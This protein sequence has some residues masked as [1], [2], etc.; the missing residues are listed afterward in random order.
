MFMDNKDF[1]NLG[2]QIR[3]SVQDAIDSMDFKQLNRTISDTVNFA[4]DEARSQMLKG[5]DAARRMDT[6]SN[7]RKGPDKGQGTGPDTNAGAY[8]TAAAA[9]AGRDAGRNA[10]RNAAGR[11]AGRDHGSWA[12]TAA[13]SGR[14]RERRRTGYES[15]RYTTER[16]STRAESPGYRAFQT[17]E[18]AGEDQ[19]AYR[20]RK[21]APSP[22]AI[23]LNQPGRISGILFTV[24]GGI[25]L[26]VVGILFLVTW[27]LA[28]VVKP[29]WGAILGS[30]GLLLVL[31]CVFGT[32]L[33]T[34]ISTR[35]R[36]KRAGLYLK[37]A[38]SRLFCDIEELA[39][40]IGK[41]RRFVVRDLQKMIEK[42]ILPEAHIDEQKTC[43]MLNEET[44]KQYLSAQQSLKQR[45]KEMA[46]LAESEKKQKKSAAAPEGKK[47]AEEDEK[48]LPEG[49]REM[50]AQGHEYLRILR[51]AND[52]IPGE[53]ISGK[54]SRLE[55]V[56]RRIFETVERQPD[57]MEEMERFMEY[58]LPTTVKLVTAYRDFDRIEIEGDNIVSAKHEIEETVDTINTAFER[59]LDDLYQDAAIDITTDASVLQTMLKKDGFAE[60][61]FSKSDLTG[62]KNHE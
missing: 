37:Q 51:E 53:A 28:L 57:Q 54:I 50:M 23:R 2:D 4:L 9:D 3:D 8:D 10:G 49:L 38:G 22:V 40:S 11:D 31:G 14:T 16:T 59:L 34:G 36:L 29:F 27:I 20:V 25:G 33:G 5:M 30:S 46:L 44:Y 62:G 58:Y 18:T 55:N 19:R 52:A 56:I 24:F 15:R 21:M 48:Q 61:D 45:E 12:G 41:S 39:R 1:S 17:S 32:M 47:K 60:S 42:G 7:G 6:G 35:G 13:G 26:G 43:L